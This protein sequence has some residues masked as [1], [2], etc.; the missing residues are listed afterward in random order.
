MT[1]ARMPDHA[2]FFWQ[3]GASFV[4]DLAGK[5]E[6]IPVGV[7]KTAIDPQGHSWVLRQR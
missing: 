5:C 4:I 3:P 2:Q 6:L 1:N 7:L